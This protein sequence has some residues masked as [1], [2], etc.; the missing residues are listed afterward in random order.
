M[1]LVETQRKMIVHVLGSK[2]FVGSQIYEHLSE[3]GFEV[4]GYSLEN[5]D[6]LSKDSIESALL[7]NPT[8]IIVMAAGITRFDDNSLNSMNDNISMIQN[9]AEFIQKNKIEQFI[10]VSS[11]DVYGKNFSGKINENLPADSTDAYARSK[12]FGE[13]ILKDCCSENGVPLLITRLSGTYGPND[14]ARSTINML[15]EPAVLNEKITIRGDGEDRRDYIHI[16]DVCKIIEKGI[17]RKL[18]GVLNLATGQSYSINEIVGFIE[19]FYPGKFSVEHVPVIEEDKKRVRHMEYDISLLKKTIPEFCPI[20]LEK[21]VELYLKNLNFFKANPSLEKMGEMNLMEKYPQTK[22]DVDKK[23]EEKTE[24]DKLIAKKFGKEFFDGDRKQ[25]Y[26]GYN[27]HPRFFSGVVEDMI[28][29][30]G[31]T[32]KSKILDVG[33][34]KG[35]MLYDFRRLCPGITVKGIDVSEYAIEN[36]KSE[37]KEFLEV[38]DAKDLSKFR[39]DEF[40]LVICITTVHNLP[41]EECKQALKEIQRVGKNAFVTVDAWRTDEEKERMDCW[42]LTAETLMCVDDWKKLFEEVGY[43]GEYY[44]FIP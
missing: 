10:F 8:D 17:K 13:S 41:L 6:L 28:K 2:G 4:K 37:V 25:G 39:D 31:L 1:W 16:Q 18:Q 30:Y 32:E 40:D 11:P 34:A 3:K 22:R 9:L 15:V 21:G 36:S 33:C 35:F 20:S 44:W 12:V 26:G 24:E 19:K 43:T 14:R 29:H 27:Y 42:N 7:V 5:C 23:A 38:G